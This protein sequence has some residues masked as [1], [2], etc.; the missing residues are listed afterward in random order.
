MDGSLGSRLWRRS[1]EGSKYTPLKVF[2][3]AGLVFVNPQRPGVV[4]LPRFE[5]LVAAFSQNVDAEWGD[6]DINIDDVWASCR[7]KSPSLAT[8]EHGAYC[9]T[10]RLGRPADP[11]GRPSLAPGEASA[12][13]PRGHAPP[14]S[15]NVPDLRAVGRPGQPTATQGCLGLRW[16]TP[17]VKFRY[18]SS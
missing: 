2:F 16:A 14:A 5:F 15:S 1:G 9:G 6:A 12:V 17:S 10:G 3:C 7:A 4:P 18:R 11:P 8:D 13:P